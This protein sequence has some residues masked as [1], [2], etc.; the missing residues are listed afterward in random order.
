MRSS[1]K[2]ARLIR[3]RFVSI[4]GWSNAMLIETASRSAAL[5]RD[6][7]SPQYPPLSGAALRPLPPPRHLASKAAHRKQDHTLPQHTRSWWACIHGVRK[8]AHGED[9]GAVGRN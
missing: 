3:P 8:H 5:D 6:D 1:L 7:F 2:I 9:E 4:S